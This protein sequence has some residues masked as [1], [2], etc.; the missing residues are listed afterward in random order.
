MGEGHNKV[1]VPVWFTALLVVLVI[2]VG[3]QSFFLYRLYTTAA[4]AELSYPSPPD[5]I[6]AVEQ[7]EEAGLPEK[8]VLPGF[9]SLQSDPFFR[10]LDW[11]P[12]Q[13]MQHM[14]ERIDQLFG[15]AFSRFDS[16]DQF[17]GLFDADTPTRPRIDVRENDDA[18]R[19]TVEMP[20]VNDSTIETKVENQT[21]Y[22]TGSVAHSSA[23]RD[24]TENRS[25]TVHRERWVS[26]FERSVYLPEPVDV[27]KMTNEYKDGILH[28][29][30]PKKKSQ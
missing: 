11:D 17:S 25:A 6:A 22:I 15:E 27:S 13:E 1:F 26:R 24:E 2:A 8:S 29:N 7:E 18:Y 14:R 10:D 4:G 19:I 16:S 30:I 3:I 21:L 5:N 20:G 23:D 9:E 12:L 28:L